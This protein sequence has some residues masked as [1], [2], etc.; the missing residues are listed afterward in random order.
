MMAE[1]VIENIFYRFD[2]YYPEKLP[3]YEINPANPQD[4]N[5]KLGEWVACIVYLSKCTS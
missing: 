4:D 1:N 2:P 5:V 3:P